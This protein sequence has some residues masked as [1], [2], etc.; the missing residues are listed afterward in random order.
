M[1]PTPEVLDPIFDECQQYFTQSQTASPAL[2]SPWLNS[3][4]AYYY[5]A[6][7]H[8]EMKTTKTDEIFAKAYEKFEAASNAEKS[9]SSGVDLL[10][11]VYHNWGMTLYVQGTHQLSGAQQAND[12]QQRDAHYTKACVSVV[13]ALYLSCY[14]TTLQ[15]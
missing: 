15:L 1:D 5:Q 12:D 2:I 9:R 13:S 3:G 8:Q 6:V 11:S 14:L 10:Y 4:I 7:R